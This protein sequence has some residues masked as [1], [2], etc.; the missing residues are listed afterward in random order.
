MNSQG[1]RDVREGYP[2]EKF[3]VEL[4]KTY[5][6]VS[7][8]NKFGLLCSPFWNIVLF[9]KIQIMYDSFAFKW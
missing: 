3:Y 8:F 7:G 2:S 9:K 6:T 4:F 1:R 5:S